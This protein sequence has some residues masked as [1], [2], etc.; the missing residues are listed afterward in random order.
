MAELSI[1]PINQLL[2]ECTGCKAHWMI[3]ADPPIRN[4]QELT[5]FTSDPNRMEGCPKRCG[6]TT[7]NMAFRVPGPVKPEGPAS[8]PFSVFTEKKS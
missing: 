8:D 3:R 7:V 5:A 2:F 4:I 6:A 1:Y